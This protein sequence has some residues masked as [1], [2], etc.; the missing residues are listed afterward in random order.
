LDFDANFVLCYHPCQE[1]AR[2]KRDSILRWSIGLHFST[3]EVLH[4]KDKQGKK[5]QYW[6]IGLHFQ[7][8]WGPSCQGQEKQ[9]KG[10]YL[11]MFFCPKLFHPLRYFNLHGRGTRE[12]KRDSILR[13]FI[14]PSLAGN[15][16]IIPGEREFVKSHH[17]WGRENRPLTFFTVLSTT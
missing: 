3:F 16:L 12:A 8:F 2:Q 11:E 14:G 10:Q 1:Q 9:K 6:L 5:G 13:W 15:N 4:A 17:G 7:P